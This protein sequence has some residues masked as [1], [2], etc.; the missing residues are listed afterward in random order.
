MLELLAVVAL[1][2]I[3]AALAVAGYRKYLYTARTADAKATIAAIHAAE[4]SYYAETLTYWPCP[5]NCT[6]LTGWHP[7]T[8]D[9]KR[10][11]WTKTSD[12]ALEAEWRKLS[13]KQDSPTSFGFFVVAGKAT[14]TPPAPLTKSA[15]TW[16]NPTTEPWYVVQAAGDADGDGTFSRFLSSSFAPGEVYVEDEAE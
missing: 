14:D 3:L 1:I 11:F 5:N 4:A 2:G 8:P 6:A 9:G 15:P 7:A 12:A 16:P 13:V 10:H